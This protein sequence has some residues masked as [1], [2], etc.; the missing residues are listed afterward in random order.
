MKKLAADNGVKWQDAADDYQL[1]SI[2]QHKKILDAAYEDDQHMLQVIDF[3]INQCAGKLPT[4]AAAIRI[5][6]S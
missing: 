5:R 3:I 4:R 1:E 6:P 2:L